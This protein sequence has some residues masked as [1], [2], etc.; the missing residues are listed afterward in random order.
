MGFF[1]TKRT[2]TRFLV[3]VPHAPDECAWAM[4]EIVGRGPQYG[5]LFWWGC[6]VGEHKAWAMLDGTGREE[7]LEEAL[8]P[9]LRRHAVVHRLSRIDGREVRQWKEA[10]DDRR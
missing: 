3:E 6:H 10:E 1:A 9:V 4:N 2:K 5:H 8:T 7:V